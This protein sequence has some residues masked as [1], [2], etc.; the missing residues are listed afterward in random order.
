MALGLPRQGTAPARFPIHTALP[1]KQVLAR[2]GRSPSALL[3]K[4]RGGPG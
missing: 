1:G 4:V 2:Q 3:T